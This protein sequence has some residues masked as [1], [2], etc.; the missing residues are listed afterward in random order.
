MTRIKITTYKNDAIML[1]ILLKL[2]PLTDS[3]LHVRSSSFAVSVQTLQSLI[4]TPSSPSA[5]PLCSTRSGA[6]P[7]PIMLRPTER[8]SKCSYALS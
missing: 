6:W 4:Y 3:S 7:I 8:K 5:I 2:G 1:R